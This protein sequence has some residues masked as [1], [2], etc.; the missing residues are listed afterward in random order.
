MSSE[1]SVSIYKATRLRIPEAVMWMKFDKIL[2]SIE[3]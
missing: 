2:V 1:R 3:M